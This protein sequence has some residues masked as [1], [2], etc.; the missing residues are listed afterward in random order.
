MQLLLRVF[1]GL[2]FLGWSI[3]AFAQSDDAGANYKTALSLVNSNK[4]KEAISYLEKVIKTSPSAYTAAAYSLLGS[5]YDNDHQPEKAITAY[6]D[7]IKA[8][9]QDQSLYYNLGLAY[10]RDKQYGEAEAAAIEAIKLDPKN[11]NSQRVYALVTFHQNKRMNALLG[12]CSFLL[13][14]SNTPRTAEAFTNM[15]S[16]LKGGMLKEDGKGTLS[17]ADIKER[18]TLNAAIATVTTSAQ[19]KKLTGTALL[20]YELKGIFTNAGQLAEKKADKSFFDKFYA[21]YFYKLAQSDN[22]PAFA[23]LVE[24]KE[25]DAGLTDWV[26]GTE[27]GQ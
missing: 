8:Y 16:I 21:A 20:E 15:Q 13:L 24:N 23:K 27:R 6:K 19:A 22:M 3:F 9:P 12:F 4:G 5:I 26:K 1:W 18:T 2:L 14:E 17:A 7:G 25:M 10:F 11:A